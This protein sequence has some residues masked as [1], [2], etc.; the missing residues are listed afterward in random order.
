MLDALT[1]FGLVCGY[2]LGFYSCFLI[3]YFKD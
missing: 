3:S 1:I 2:A